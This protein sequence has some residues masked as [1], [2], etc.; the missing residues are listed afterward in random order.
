MHPGALCELVV[1][2]EDGS[3]TVKPLPI[4]HQNVDKEQLIEAAREEV[5]LGMLSLFQDI[6][7]LQLNEEQL[8]HF[9]ALTDH[10]AKGI[11]VLSGGPG[12][13]SCTGPR[14]S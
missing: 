11:H 10:S 2:H 1:E 8:Q 13:C 5:G 7:D 3:L 9:Q 6:P 14:P 4:Q 12:T